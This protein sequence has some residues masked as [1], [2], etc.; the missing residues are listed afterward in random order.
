MSHEP[1]AQVRARVLTLVAG[2]KS[3]SANFSEAKESES[4]D[5]EKDDKA[6]ADDYCSNAS[7][8]EYK[9]SV[10][11]RLEEMG[12]TIRSIVDSIEEIKKINN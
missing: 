4:E 10:E 9:E 11:S 3:D 7:F 12:A 8:S 5:K 6:K 2:L 1:W